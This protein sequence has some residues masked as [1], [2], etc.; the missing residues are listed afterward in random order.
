M[1]GGIKYLRNITFSCCHRDFVVAQLTA[2][3]MS[4]DG[5]TGSRVE[6]DL[7]QGLAVLVAI[8][9]AGLVT[10]AWSQQLLSLEQF[11]KPHE[12]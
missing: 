9:S 5:D 8:R 6:L 11:V 2:Y 1:L 7:K 12:D 3:W 4:L 10:N